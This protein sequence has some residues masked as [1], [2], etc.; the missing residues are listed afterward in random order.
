LNFISE[1]DLDVEKGGI[2]VGYITEE[3]TKVLGSWKIPYEV[4][5]IDGVKVKAEVTE[6][7]KPRE[8]SDSQPIE[9][10]LTMGEDDFKGMNY[11]EAERLFREMG[12][13]KFKYQTV[14]ARTE[15]VADTICYIEIAEWFIG[16]SDFAKGDRFNADAIVTFFSYEYK[17]PSTPASVSYSTNDYETAKKGNAG[18]YSYVDRGSSYDIYWIIDFDEGYVYY[19]TEGNGDST[20]DRLK[21]EAGTLNDAIT[22]TYHNGGDIWS[23]KLHFKYVNH[24]ETLIMVEQNGFEYQYSTT[25][26]EDALA[27]RATKKIKDY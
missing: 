3:P 17:S 9:I 7:T 18:V 14:D 19:F 21:I 13:T 22:I 2:I 27:L 12:F 24:P 5:S 4:L 16:D 11:Q 10:T 25:D 8:P 1:E 20:C 6:T 26:L 23:N 15:S